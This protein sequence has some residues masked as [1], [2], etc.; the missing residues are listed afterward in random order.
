[1]GKK[2]SK[3]HNFL[4]DNVFKSERP[5]GDQYWKFDPSRKPPVQNVYPRDIE[6]WDLPS[7]IDGALKWSDNITYFFKGDHF[8]R[9]NDRRFAID[10]GDPK[11]P[12]PTAPWWFG[13]Q[14]IL[15]VKQMLFL[16]SEQFPKRN[17]VVRFEWVYKLELYCCK[18][19]Q[20]KSQPRN[21]FWE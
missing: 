8:Y 15:K 1:M 17:C 6:K 5:L 7:N 9:F 10:S 14:P 4:Q 19:R 3:L 18:K 12:R 21:W 20:K 11:F 13:C 16:R 2:N